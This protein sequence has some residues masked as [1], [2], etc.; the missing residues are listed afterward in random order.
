MAWGTFDQCRSRLDEI[1]RQQSLEPISGKVV[2]TLHGLVRSRDCMEG[3]GNYLAQEGGYTWLNISYASARGSLD[4]HARALARVLENLDPGVTEINFVCHSLGNLV[5]RRYL[6]EAAQPQPAWQVDPRLKRMVMLGPP[7]NGAELARLFKNNDLMGLVT[8][9]SGKQLAISWE[10]TQKK[11]A[12]PAFEFG[13][14]AG[15]RSDD[16][17]TNP[18]IHGDDDFVVG[19][20]ETRLSGARDFLLVPCLHGHLM[21]NAQVRQCTL[22]FLR[23]GFFTAAGERHPIE[24][25]PARS[26]KLVRP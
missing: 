2:I 20:E 22:R 11:L 7:N 14:I 23:E 21:Q 3:I 5:V 10:D 12:T 13:V 19:V 4:D 9:E 25:D 6:G 1:K 26:A 18:F 8:G 15:G 24:V 16:R 17:G